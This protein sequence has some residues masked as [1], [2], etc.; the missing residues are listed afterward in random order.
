MEVLL[1]PQNSFTNISVNGKPR[2][3]LKGVGEMGIFSVLFNSLQSEHQR[4][5]HMNMKAGKA[6]ESLLVKQ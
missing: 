4:G 5:S 3:N 6:L 2:Q 1:L